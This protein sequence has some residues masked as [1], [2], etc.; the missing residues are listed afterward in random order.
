M[1]TCKPEISLFELEEDLQAYLQDFFGPEAPLCLGR[2]FMNLHSVLGEHTKGMRG[3]IPQ[4]P[5]YHHFLSAK[6]SF[7]TSSHQKKNL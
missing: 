6:S 4:K 7:L 1:T 5:L 3:Y 2:F